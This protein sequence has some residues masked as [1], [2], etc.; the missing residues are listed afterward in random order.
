MICSAQ[1]R[2][3]TVTE[4]RAGRLPNAGRRR[5]SATEWNDA[6]NIDYSGKDTRAVLP[7]RSRS[8]RPFAVS[9]P[10]HQGFTG[11]APV[12]RPRPADGCSSF[13]P[14]LPALPVVTRRDKWVAGTSRE[15]LK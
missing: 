8:V 12:R 13:G 4:C 9:P 7:S 10:V 11:P 15:N 6:L 14:A 1:P 3:R 2:D 5:R